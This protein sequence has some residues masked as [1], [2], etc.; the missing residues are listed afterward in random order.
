ASIGALKARLAKQVEARATDSRNPFSMAGFEVS[1]AP[2]VE[3]KTEEAPD[4][5][6]LLSTLAAQIDAKGRFVMGGEVM[7]LA[8]GNKRLKV[9][10]K[11]PV[12]HGG[13]VYELEISA[14]DTARFTVRYKGEE[15]TRPIVQ[16]L[17]A[18]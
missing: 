6:D 10:S 5:M 15:F 17:P 4:G 2:V 12:T 1:A 11:I 7:L 18:K 13:L 3:T 16:K 14:I 9:G 8:S